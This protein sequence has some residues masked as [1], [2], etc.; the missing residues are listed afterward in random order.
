MFNS[1]LDEENSILDNSVMDTSVMDSSSI[2]D[3]VVLN[4]SDF[5]N[6]SSEV[7]NVTSHYD[8]L[9]LNQT[10]LIDH[11]KVNTLLVLT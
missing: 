3:S 8:I 7:G 10:D 5:E 4:K 2:L 11:C 6:S 1:S 9:D